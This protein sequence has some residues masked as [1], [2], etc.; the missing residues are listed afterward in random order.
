MELT[1]PAAV[2]CERAAELSIDARLYDLQ[3]RDVNE[4]GLPRREV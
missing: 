4:G 3:I 1:E 2:G